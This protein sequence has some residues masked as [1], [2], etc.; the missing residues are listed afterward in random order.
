ML[1]QATGHNRFDWIIT[2]DVVACYSVAEVQAL[3]GT[4]EALLNPQRDGSNILHLTSIMR[5][6]GG[7]SAFTWLTLEQWAEVIPSHNWMAAGS[8][9]FIAAVV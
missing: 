1:R 9:E 8:R 6:I 2:E 4:V 5:Q 7:D 3:Q